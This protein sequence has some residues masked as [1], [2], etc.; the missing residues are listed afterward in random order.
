MHTQTCEPT[1]TETLPCNFTYYIKGALLICRMAKCAF[2]VCWF[3][4][5][6]LRSVFVESLSFVRI[7]VGQQPRKRRKYTFLILILFF[8]GMASAEQI[9]IVSEHVQAFW[10][11]CVYCYCSFFARKKNSFFSLSLLLLFT[12]ASA[13]IMTQIFGAFETA[14]KSRNYVAPCAAATCHSSTSPLCDFQHVIEIVRHMTKGN[15]ENI[16]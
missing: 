13:L 6:L 11:W 15:T 10:S 8:R 4:S 3:F 12:T 16:P 9:S 2:C 14:L 7:P 1:H 5:S